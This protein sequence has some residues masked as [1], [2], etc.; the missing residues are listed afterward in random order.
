MEQIIIG[1]YNPNLLHEEL[2]AAG[3]EATLQ[4]FP[5]ENGVRVLLEYPDADDSVVQAIIA[6]HVASAESKN[7]AASRRYVIAVNYLKSVDW[8]TLQTEIAALPLQYRSP[9][10]TL[11]KISKALTTVVAQIESE[12]E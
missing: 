12:M 6:S 4:S 1:D 8:A 3:V 2:A 7:E 11:G 10:A 5:A 9:I